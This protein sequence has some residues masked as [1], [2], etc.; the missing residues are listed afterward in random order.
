M[1]LTDQIRERKN[2]THQEKI[3]REI[4]IPYSLAALQCI[5]TMVLILDGHSEIGTRM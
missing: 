1:P 5:G 2:V 4:E 3:K